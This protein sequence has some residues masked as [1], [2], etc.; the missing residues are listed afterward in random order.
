MTKFKLLK[1]IDIQDKYRSKITHIIVRY[2]N[3]SSIKSIY[4]KISVDLDN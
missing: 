2:K 1:K 4:A 3:S